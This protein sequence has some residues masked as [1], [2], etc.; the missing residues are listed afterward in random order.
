MEET[1]S[2]CVCAS[3]VV[4]GCPRTCEVTRAK[5]VLALGSSVHRPGSFRNVSPDVQRNTRVPVRE[6]PLN[7]SV[8]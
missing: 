1:Y 3:G 5:P 7:S 2:G 6:S 4:H 8:L